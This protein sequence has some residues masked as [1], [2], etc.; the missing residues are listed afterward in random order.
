[1]SEKLPGIKLFDLSGKAAIITGGSKGLGLAMAEGLASAGANVML[2]SRN[3]NECEESAIR[4]NK[5][6]GVKAI[7]FEA[8]V[9]NKDQTEA[10]AKAAFDAFGR[11][12]VLINSAGINIRGAID[13]LQLEEFSKV[14]DINVTGTWLCCK[15]VTP[16]M[17]EA[18][19][20]SIINLASTLG[21]VGLSNRTPYASS[22]GAV[23]QMTRA[24][25]LEFAPFKITVNAICPGPFLTEMNLPIADTEEGK[26]FVVGATALGRWGRLEEIQGAAIYLASDAATYM[27]G[28]MLTVDGGW[29]AR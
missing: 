10:M 29:T 24:L 5:L 18:G 9:V 27:V 17:K 22:K 7:A 28:S 20:G 23:V 6:Y 25:G 21:L 11:I 14:M 2:V 13:E 19:K 16:Y 8:D 1:M 26:K 12:D 15:A 4:I 3:L